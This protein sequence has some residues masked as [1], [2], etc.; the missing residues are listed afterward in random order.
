MSEH[1]NGHVRGIL[2]EVVQ[3]RDPHGRARRPGEI[4]ASRHTV[5]VEYNDYDG[6]G[7][8]LVDYDVH[9][10]ERAFPPDCPA[11]VNGQVCDAPLDFRG[12]CYQADR[13][14]KEE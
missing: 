7:P 10:L 1:P 11:T 5:T 3:D 14:D 13:H 9:D 4:V 12:H 2:G 8:Y 6:T